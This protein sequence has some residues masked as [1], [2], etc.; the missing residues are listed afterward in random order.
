MRNYLLVMNSD[1]TEDEKSLQEK[2][3]EYMWGKRKFEVCIWGIGV[4]VSNIG[5]QAE[6]IFYPKTFEERIIVP[7]Y[8]IGSGICVLSFILYF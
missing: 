5:N 4:T 6:G 3:I 1:S 8:M 2:E 7:I